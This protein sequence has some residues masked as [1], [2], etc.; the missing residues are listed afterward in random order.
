MQISYSS[1]LQSPVSLCAENHKN[2]GLIQ[3]KNQ[4]SSLKNLYTPIALF[5][6]IQVASHYPI[7]F[8]GEDDIFPVAITGIQPPPPPQS[9]APV[10]LYQPALR[11]LYPFALHKLPDQAAG[12]LLF[13]E[14][15]KQVIPSVNDSGA[16]ALFDTHGNPTD[17][18]QQIGTAAAQFYTGHMQAKKLAM[19]LKN[20]AI[21]TPSQLEF[22]VVEDG[23]QKI[24]P[25]YMID[26]QAYR[27]LPAHIVHN[28][29]QR[30]WLDAAGLIILSH[31]HWYRHLKAAQFAEQV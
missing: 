10:A 17:I 3:K 30:G 2:Y 1:I 12:V 9:D 29:H 25:F 20:A 19:V 14:N 4:L 18:L 27:R 22:K 23:V 28:W 8:M 16:L 5:E 31:L 24:Y 15:S 11:Q 7:F 6:F 26:E 13:D 21:L